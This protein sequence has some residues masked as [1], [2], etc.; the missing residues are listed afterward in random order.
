V[1]SW[2][3]DHW[4]GSAERRAE[5]WR[6]LDETLAEKLDWDVALLQEC[7]PPAGRAGVVFRPV[8]GGP[9]GTAVVTRGADVRHLDLE[10]DSL[11]GCL[12]A[13]EVDLGERGGVVPDHESHR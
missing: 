13:A 5:A 11:P 4:Q 9:W 8:R 6:Y 7:V 12:V 10:D 1:V 2:N 3:L